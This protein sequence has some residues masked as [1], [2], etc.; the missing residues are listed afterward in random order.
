MSEAGV[1][2]ADAGAGHV[3]GSG[4]PGDTAMV[5]ERRYRRLLVLLPR[6]YR[7]DR[8]E[9]MLTVLMDSAP[10]QRRWPKVGEVLSL[11]THSLKVR[12]G[13]SAEG[14]PS[15]AARPLVRAVALLGTLYFS[16]L[17]AVGL[18][19]GLRWNWGIYHSDFNHSDLDG[20]HHP[21]AEIALVQVAGLLWLAAHV[22]V[23]LGWRR[24]VRTLGLVLLVLAAT[25][26]TGGYTALAAVPP[27]IAAGALIA[28]GRRR[29]EAAPRARWWF[30]GLAAVAAVVGYLDWSGRG[31][32]GRPAATGPLAAVAVAVAMVGV[33]RAW[34]RPEWVLAAAVIGGMACAQ[35]ALDLNHYPD[36]WLAGFDPQLRLILIGESVLIHAALYAVLRQRRSG[37]AT[38]TGE[39]V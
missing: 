10:Q 2:G 15:D 22:A 9:E 4:G 34:R 23:L 16:F 26:V 28:T 35:R 1:A 17:S 12:S 37:V 20:H 38:G 21:V 18:V 32:L 31:T 30:A 19:M 3:A 36:W 25:Q 39:A 29:I 13:L 7:A 33:M 11:A 27:L 6:A 24:S 8:G 5:L 14:V